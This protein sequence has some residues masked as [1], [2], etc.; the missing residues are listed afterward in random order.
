MIATE[1]IQLL[2]D[3]HSRFI[4]HRDLKP[5][6]LLISQNGTGPITLI[7]F[8]LS[9]KFIDHTNQHIPRLEEKSFRGTL[10]YASSNM[11]QGIENSRRDDLESLGYVLVYLAKG[12][13]P[14]QGL[15]VPAK[16]KGDLI[17]RVKMKTQTKELCQGL[18]PVFLEY[19]KVVRNLSFA[20]EPDY[21]SLISM[22]GQV[23]AEER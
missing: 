18:H 5:E 15:K 8:G 6:N 9:K 16:E 4:I 11:H 17:G 19:M 20:E 23:L 3:L 2:W 1:S 12:K 10:R 22:F 13:L 7:D 14:W 21:G